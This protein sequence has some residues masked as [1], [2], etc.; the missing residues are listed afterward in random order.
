MAH[1]RLRTTPI[2]KV[3][4]QQGFTTDEMGFRDQFARHGARK[5]RRCRRLGRAEITT[6]GMRFWT[7]SA[8]QI[9]QKA[10]SSAAQRGRQHPRFF[11]LENAA[12][13]DAGLTEWERCG[14]SE[15]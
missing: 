13:V 1:P 11:A 15:A 12:A 4:L 5:E 7:Q 6:G 9:I 14:S 8:Q 2:F 10:R 3:G